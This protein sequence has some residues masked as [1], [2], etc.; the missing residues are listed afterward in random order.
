[1]IWNPYDWLNKGYSFYKAA[2]VVISDRH[3]LTHYFNTPFKLLYTNN[4]TE[5]FSYKGGCGVH[6]HM[7]IEVL[8]RRAG[9]SYR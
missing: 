5:C 3:G 4:K 7:C 1:M 2:K 8:K 9:L 6:G